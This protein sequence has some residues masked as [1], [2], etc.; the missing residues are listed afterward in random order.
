M[1]ELSDRLAT[2]S[3][4]KRALLEKLRAADPIPRIPDG[5]APLSAE[6]R[7]LWYVLPLAP[8]YPVYTIQLGYRLRGPLDL[9]ALAGA[10][11]ELVARHEMLRAA[12]TERDGEPVQTVHDGAAWEPRLVE[13]PADQW[14][15]SEA[16]YLADE[17]AQ[18]T[19]DL[20]AGETFRAA[21]LRLSEDEHHLL[22][23]VH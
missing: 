21:L 7:R 16:R 18:S 19:Y 12:F 3:P 9:D 4:A 2:L 6:Q 11:R 1:T 14:A 17:F 8:G 5:P 13:V 20:A 10:L 22:I 15:A 23:G